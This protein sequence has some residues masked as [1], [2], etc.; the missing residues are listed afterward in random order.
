[1]NRRS[2]HD[3]FAPLSHRDGPDTERAAAESVVEAATGVRARLREL[4]RLYGPMTDQELHE[5]YVDVFGDCD[6][7]AVER[8]RNDLK[9]L[10]EIKDTGT[11][12]T[13][14]RGRR[15]VVWG[16]AGASTP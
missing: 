3:V 14:R 15:M 6:Y 16:L 9:N 7:M 13:S 10:S 11:R 5:R 1:M 2:G 4:F 12:R 8:R